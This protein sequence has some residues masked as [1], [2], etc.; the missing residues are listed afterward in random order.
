MHIT[1]YFKPTDS[2]QDNIPVSIF[3]AYLGENLRNVFTG[4]EVITKIDTQVS[5]STE[6]KTGL[7]NMF[8][9]IDALPDESSKRA[10][11][12]EIR[13]V[14]YIAGNENYPDYNTSA[15]LNTR[16]GVIFNGV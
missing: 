11:I 4:T 7:N 6:A 2:D 16:L 3:C 15:Q 1:E 8:A 12:S 14:L 13:D 5:L 9:Y 10:A